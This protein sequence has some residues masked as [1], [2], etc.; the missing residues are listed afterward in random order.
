MMGGR[1]LER[2]YFDKKIFSELG[3]QSLSI[4]ILVQIIC[5]TVVKLKLKNNLKGT[6]IK[7]IGF[8]C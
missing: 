3:T 7:F 1:S 4:L 6:N 2:F 8:Q 5:F